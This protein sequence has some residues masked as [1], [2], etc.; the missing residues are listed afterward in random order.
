MA[1]AARMTAAAILFACLPFL[2]QNSAAQASGGAAPLSVH[3]KGS[4]DWSV[5]AGGALPVD[6]LD[7]R[8]DRHLSLVAVELGRIMSGP[9]GPGPLA[10]QFE[11]LLQVMPIVVR[12]PQDFWGVGITPVF[13]WSFARWTHVHPFAELAAG[14]ML[15]DWET[16]GDGRVARNF[17]EQIG[18]G[19]RIGN[20]SGRALVA[21][22]RFQHISNGSP[23]LPSPGVDTHQMYIGVSIMR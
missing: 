3:R 19:V 12:G 10:G 1:A 20:P 2:A 22:Y 15:I 6:L 11:I 7:A 21:G 4:I 16:P 23:D 17:N 9:K 8:S 18:I 5:I 13:R 14:L